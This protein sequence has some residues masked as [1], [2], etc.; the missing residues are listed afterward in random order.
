[1]KDCKLPCQ[2]LWSHIVKIKKKLFIAGFTILTFFIFF[3]NKSHVCNVLALVYETIC[4]VINC[5]CFL[6]ENLCFEIQPFESP[7]TTAIH[8]QI[9]TSLS[10]ESHLVLF[11]EYPILSVP[12][13]LQTILCKNVTYVHVPKE[14]CSTGVRQ[15][16]IQA[17]YTV[18]H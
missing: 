10:T 5:T 7:A 16:Q 18:L 6:L 17:N 8:M 14:M 11:F 3:A 9:W 13:P 15:H 1:M 12:L 2:S 4:L